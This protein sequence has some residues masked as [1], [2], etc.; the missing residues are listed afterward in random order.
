MGQHKHLIAE[1]SA[2]DLREDGSTTPLVIPPSQGV[3]EDVESELT[4]SKAWLIAREERRVE[5]A[6]VVRGI[7]VI[8]DTVVEVV[9]QV[10][11]Q[12]GIRS[13]S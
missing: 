2:D 1:V 6:K 4:A 5:V 11:A 13:R 8:L 3:V 9:R 7:V 12:Q 10:A